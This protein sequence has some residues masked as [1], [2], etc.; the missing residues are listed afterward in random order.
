MDG[1][2]AATI[3]LSSVLERNYPA[4]VD[5]PL[6]LFRRKGKKGNPALASW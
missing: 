6:A 3:Q 4:R 5:L 2:S 1:D